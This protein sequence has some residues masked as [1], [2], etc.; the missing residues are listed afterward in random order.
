MS[1]INKAIIIGNLGKDPELRSMPN[2]KAVCNM[3]VATSEKWKDQSGQAQEK[4]EWHKISL[5]DRIAEVAAE[6]LHKGSKVYLEGKITTRKWQ[7]Q[8]G[9]DRYSTEIV[10]NKL[11]FLDSANGG[12]TIEG[13]Q[14]GGQQQQGYQQ[15]QQQGGHQAPQQN[16]SE[17]QNKSGQ[18]PQSNSQQN[19]QNQGGYTKRP[20][21]SG[22]GQAPQDG[23]FDD[24]IP[25]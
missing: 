13:G 17:Q 15:Y 23:D 10:A 12:Q 14:Q 18:A 8:D 11:E 5:F 6:Y 2:G 4:T 7:D 3:V 1:G 9:N 20:M 21:N 19:N 24:D 16:Q 22:G 25:F